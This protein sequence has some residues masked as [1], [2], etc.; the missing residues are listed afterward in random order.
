M[1]LNIFPDNQAHPAILQVANSGPLEPLLIYPSSRPCARGT[2]GYRPVGDLC[3]HFGRIAD[4]Q[5][6]MEHFQEGP[7]TAGYRL[8]CY[9]GR[10]RCDEPPALCASPLLVSSRILPVFRQSRG[11]R[12]VAQ[13]PK[14][15]VFPERQDGL[16]QALRKPE[17]TNQGIRQFRS[18]LGKR[19]A[20]PVCGQRLGAYRPD[21][22]GG[23]CLRR[24]N[25]PAGEAYFVRAF[26]GTAEFDQLAGQ[27][28]TA[29]E[30]GQFQ[31]PVADQV[32]QW[33]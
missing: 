12:V 6:G 1:K 16:D 11:E 21:F 28:V 8:R 27:P 4:R 23:S 9:A 5:A 33:M 29:Y 30:R 22:F 18:R 14:R 3:G 19:S 17:F 31:L 32:E 10:R 2:G 24:L 26:L 25:L 7:P 13:H 20:L 15:L